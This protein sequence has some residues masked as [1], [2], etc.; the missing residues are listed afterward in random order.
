MNANTVARRNV[1]SVGSTLEAKFKMKGQSITF[2]MGVNATDR[3]FEAVTALTGK[4]MPEKYAME[5]GRLIDAYTDGHKYVFAK[6][7][8][9]Y[10]EEDF[11]IGL[12]EFLSE[13]GIEPV[14]IATGGKSSAFEGI[15]KSKLQP[16]H[17]PIIMTGADFEEIDEAAQGVKPDFFIGHSKGYYISHKFQV[18]L[19]RVGF[20]IHDR[21]GGQRILHVGY[22]GAHRLFE[23][24]VNS[25]LEYKQN[26]NPIGYK[27]F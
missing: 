2:P 20:P 8:V 3:F 13:I 4:P 27:Y 15:I 10:G 26:A 7:A 11:V 21:L 25:L 1:P 12:T 18:P 19:I 9:I 14:L 22:E 16:G 24:V 6:R 17:D 5:R 23:S